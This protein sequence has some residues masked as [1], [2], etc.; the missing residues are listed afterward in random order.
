MKGLAFLVLAPAF[1]AALSFVVM[2]LWN[3][4]VPGLFSGPVIGFWQ[5]AG[6]LVLSRIL[7]GGFRGR[8][9]PGGWRQHWAQHER[10]SRMSPE[11]RER[12]REKARQWRS[13]SHEERRAFKRGFCGSGWYDQGVGGSGGGVADEGTRPKES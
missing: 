10:W 13:M 2:L 6:L 12:F 4:L 7:F 3:A 5:A 9:G 8:G 11:E 1:V